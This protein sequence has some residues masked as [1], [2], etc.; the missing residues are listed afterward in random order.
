MDEEEVAARIRLL[1]RAML[2]PLPG[3]VSP[4]P[5]PR[6]APDL[7]GR[8]E[9]AEKT[10][11]RIV[12]SGALKDSDAEKFRRISDV[13]IRD[14]MRESLRGGAGDVAATINVTVAG[15]GTVSVS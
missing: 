7:A 9:A 3:G 13:A 2:T 4:I 15:T 5:Q 8:F 10:V 14:A 6:P 1:E 12:E 11:D